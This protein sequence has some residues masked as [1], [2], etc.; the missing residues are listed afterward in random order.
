M[1]R[2]P[3]SL[4]EG[5]GVDEVWLL[6]EGSWHLG[7]LSVSC[8]ITFVLEFRDKSPVSRKENGENEAGA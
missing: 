3:W 7:K 1:E 6:Q 8:R 4:T 5:P 2:G